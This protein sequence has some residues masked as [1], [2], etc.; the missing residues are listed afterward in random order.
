MRTLPKL[1]ARSVRVRRLSVLATLL[2][3]AVSPATA[4]AQMPRIEVRNDA[5]G[6]RIQVNGTDMLLRGVNWDYF[7]IGTNYSYSLWAQPDDVIKTAL[8]REM[9]LLKVMGV[10]V[11]RQYNGVPPRWVK[12]IYEQHGIYT[13]L[14]HALGRYGTTINGVFQAGP[15]I[16]IRRSVRRS[17]TKSS[18]S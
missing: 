18:L 11:I 8:D 9:G 14:N 2:V 4:S 7:P 3:A 15:I 13:A 6:S 5:A 1:A 12:Y 16:Q 17:R 10:N